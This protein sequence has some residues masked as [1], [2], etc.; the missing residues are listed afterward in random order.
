MQKIICDAGDTISR[1]NQ[2]LRGWSLQELSPLPDIA[3]LP[4]LCQLQTPAGMQ[5]IISATSLTRQG[6][7]VVEWLW[8]LASCHGHLPRHIR[9]REG[10]R[11][12]A[13]CRRQAL[14]AAGHQKSPGGLRTGHAPA[15][16]PTFGSLFRHPGWAHCQNSCSLVTTADPCKSCSRYIVANTETT[17]L[18]WSQMHS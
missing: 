18:F 5:G 3:A 9:S 13:C 17:W 11:K 16:R 12:P 1:A 8:V 4:C 14:P 2:L 7:L 15:A 10:S 6:G